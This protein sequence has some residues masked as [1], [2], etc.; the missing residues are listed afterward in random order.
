MGIS[1]CWDNGNKKEKTEQNIQP[2]A[3]KKNKTKPKMSKIH[4]FLKIGD[5]G[6][7]NLFHD[8]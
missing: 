5:L 4:D 6:K 7:A 1:A 3:K 8:E 2:P